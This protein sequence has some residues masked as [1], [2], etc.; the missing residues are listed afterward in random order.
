[1]ILFFVSITLFVIVVMDTSDRI[2]F[3]IKNEVLKII[4]YL[5]F[6]ICGVLEFIRD[7]KMIF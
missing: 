7:I 6:L 4:I 2:K 3:S 1:M 5:G